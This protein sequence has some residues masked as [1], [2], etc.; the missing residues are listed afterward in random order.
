MSIFRKQKNTDMLKIFIKKFNTLI[1]HEHPFRLLLIRLFM[2]SGISRLFTIDREYYKIRFYPTSLSQ[3]LYLNPRDR[4]DDEDFFISYLREGDIVIDVGANIGT[5]TLLSASLT[6]EEGKVYSFEPNS[7]TYKYLL[8]NIKLN[9]FNN[10]ET[11]CMA[12]GDKTA[13]AELA[14]LRSDDMN[15]IL[16]HKSENI[17]T[18][19]IKLSKLDNLLTSSIKRINLLK[20]DTEGYELFVLKGAENV[21]DKTDCIYYE[22]WEKHYTKFNYKTQDVLAFL[23]GKGFKIFRIIENELIREIK[24]PSNYESSQLEN[25]IAVKDVEAFIKRTGWEVEG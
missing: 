15:H 25:L 6:K 10:V 17:R 5:L 11:F 8:K 3:T 19:K 9:G 4:Q 14:D 2:G 23:S 7:R 16:S 13:I 24:D 1:H 20:I 18:I 21:L 22:S 12:L